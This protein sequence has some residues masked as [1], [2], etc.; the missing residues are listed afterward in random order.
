MPAL[1]NQHFVPKCL[2]RP[3]A[4]TG[5]DRSINLYNLRHKRT[6]TNAP[7]KGQC[8]RDYLYGKD[9]KIEQMLSKVEAGYSRIMRRIND[10]G[11]EDEHDLNDLRFFTL[12]QL[13][14]TEMAIERARFAMNK[15]HASVFGE[16]DDTSIPSNHHLMIDSLKLCIEA[17]HRISD[18]KAR[19]IE[20]CTTT[21]FIISDDPSIFTNRFALQRLQNE[22]FGM[23]SSGVLFLMPLTPRLCFICY[24]GQV[25]TAP[26]LGSGRILLTKQDDVEAINE[27]QYLKA[28]EN[29]YF[30]RWDDREQIAMSFEAVL[31]GR[32]KEWAQT[33]HFIPDGVDEIG[34]RY[35]LGTAE[36]AKQARQWLIQLTFRHPKPTH[37]PSAIKYRSSP[38]TFYDGSSVGHVRKAEWLRKRDR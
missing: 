2:L 7:I 25:Y 22:S 15:M 34:E 11:K 28:S 18:L 5:N 31:E 19:L 17:R 13:M 8:A 3:F 37:W 26:N 36:E 33:R 1:K 9:G 4:I 32:P 27:F 21:E 29:I 38:K 20:N 24:D 6:I 35:V 14:R 16:V 30:S 12:L 23:M 10:G